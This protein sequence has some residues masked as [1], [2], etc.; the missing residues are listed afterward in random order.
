[1]E[2]TKL[3]DELLSQSTSGMDVLIHLMVIHQSE[4]CD[5]FIKEK[6]SYALDRINPLYSRLISGIYVHNYNERLHELYPLK[7]KESEFYKDNYTYI[8]KY[9]PEMKYM[10]HMYRIFRIDLYD[11]YSMYRFIKNNTNVTLQQLVSLCSNPHR[12]SD[13][14]WML[15]ILNNEKV[16]YRD[17]LTGAIIEIDFERNASKMV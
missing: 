1:M 14:E 2:T 6:L 17:S 9:K 13:I 15:K 12:T 3:V 11:R 16:Q 8:C 5:L 4:S 10:D 7:L